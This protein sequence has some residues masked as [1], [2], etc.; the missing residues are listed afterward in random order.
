ML[1]GLI[2]RKLDAEEK[3]LGESVDYIRHIVDV[4]P[5]AFFRF[6]S[7]LPFA[8]SRKVLPKDAWFVAQIVALEHE[9]CG[10]CLQI[11]VNLARQSGVDGR[12]IQAVLD[13]ED[14]PAE[15]ADVIRFTRSV[16][17]ADE[18]DDSLRETLRE[19]YGERGLI[20]LAYAIAGSRIPPTVKRALG[21]AK[22]CSLVPVHVR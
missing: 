20:E 22:S 2:K 19:R 16:V 21:Y 7:I 4:S 8:N 11:G 15:M 10:T 13:G 17:N 9:D 3:K 6:A 1:R 12:L 5:G 18:D 14:V